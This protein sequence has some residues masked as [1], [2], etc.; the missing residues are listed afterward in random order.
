M[1][2]RYGYGGTDLLEELAGGGGVQGLDRFD[3]FEEVYFRLGS[4]GLEVLGDV[5]GVE[6]VG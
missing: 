5:E 6:T 2:H 1:V 4:V 3:V